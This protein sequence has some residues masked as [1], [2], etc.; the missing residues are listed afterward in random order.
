VISPCV[1]LGNVQVR[2]CGGNKVRIEWGES[3]QEMC[4]L[5]YR[6]ALWYLYSFIKAIKKNTSTLHIYIYIIQV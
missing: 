2:T 4:L 5:E 1:L 3:I 6:Y